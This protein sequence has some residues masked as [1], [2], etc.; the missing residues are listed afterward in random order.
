VTTPILDPLSAL[1]AGSVDLLD[2]P[3]SVRRAAVA[4][5]ED[6]GNFLADT[7]GSRCGIYPQGS[8][9]IGTAIRPPAD[10]QY[11]I[12]LVFQD[13]I[14]KEQTTQAELKERVGA[15][16]GSY[17]SHKA[18]EADGP[19]DF[20]EKRRCWTLS[21][22]K[23]GF[24]LDVLPAV[25]NRDPETPFNAILLTDTKLRPWQHANPKDYA[26][27]FRRRSEE[28]LRRIEAK[29][30][31]E[32]VDDIPNWEVRSTLQRIVQVLKW[33]CYSAF[34]DDIDNR[35]PS[36]LIT[37][38]AAWAYRGQQNLGT[39]LLEVIDGMPNYI[40]ASNG[41]WEVLNPAHDQENFT[42]KW[43]EPETAHR[44]NVFEAWLKEAQYDL[45]QAYD[46]QNAGIDVLVGR[47]S[48]AFDPSILAK[49]AANWGRKTV[50]MRTQ[51]N[52]TIAGGTAAL[53]TGL[54]RTSPQHSFYGH[55]T[56]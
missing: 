8:F 56:R 30:R 26:V 5:Y 3:P 25:P 16:L 1:L 37:T 41:R 27:W 24:H 52:L 15:I 22:E 6:V 31:A 38:L 12:D 10:T 28:M 35:P 54:G 47:L 34:A 9:L 4:R 43:N 19:D 46:S 18:G 11:D 45:E 14:D 36:I 17:N 50:E 23:D 29:A 33:H 21:Y 7:G 42:D 51:G 53:G 40:D 48:T 44:R 49:S 39:A 20:F 13:D 55:E 32:N 2:I